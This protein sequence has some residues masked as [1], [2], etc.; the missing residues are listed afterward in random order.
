MFLYVR[1]TRGNRVAVDSINA[2]LY[3][4]TAV[5][6]FC[7]QAG[8][9]LIPLL[10]LLHCYVNVVRAGHYAAAALVSCVCKKDTC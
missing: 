3:A 1:R 8:C 10:L 4:A 2:G 9:V 6:F 7:M 5:A